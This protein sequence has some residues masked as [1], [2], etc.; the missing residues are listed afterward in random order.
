MSDGSTAWNFTY[1]ADGL[2]TKRTSGSTTYTYTYNGDKLSQMTVGSDTLYFSYDASGNPLS[3]RYNGAYYYYVTTIQGDVIRILDENGSV[4][5]YYRYDAYGRPL[6]SG[7]TMAD[8]NPLR[9][10][11]YI[12]D[13]ETGLYYVSSRYYDPEIGRWINADDAEI[14]LEDY[15]AMLQYNLFAYCWNNPVNMYDPDG[16][17]TLALAGGGYL[18]TA[19]TLGASIIWNPVG[20]V[21]LGAVVVTTVVVV[22]YS[23]FL[24]SLK[25][26]PFLF[27]TLP[28]YSTFT[29][30]SSVITFVALIYV[31][32]ITLVFLYIL[33]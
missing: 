24:S 18:A 5:A 1:N 3:F 21:I 13:K 10:R 9:Y 26:P 4:V 19:G 22:V 33:S 16:Y 2:R 30:T 31:S 6:S 23:C 11:G 17:W 8:I 27:V 15:E 12:Y 28:S 32:V 20:W 25:G 7:G 29:T 14:L